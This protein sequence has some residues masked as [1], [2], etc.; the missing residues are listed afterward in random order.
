VGFRDLNEFRNENA[1]EVGRTFKSF[2]LSMEVLRRAF[3]NEKE[4]FTYIEKF[5]PSVTYFQNCDILGF[6]L[7]P[8]YSVESMI[9]GD[10][11]NKILN[12]SKQ[13]Q[14]A[15]F[16]LKDSETGRRFLQL[17]EPTF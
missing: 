1:Q 16:I 13:D 10:A 9:N 6:K 11:L 12:P 7:E 17:V 3:R 5:Y 8:K 4:K 2:Y 15:I 14:S